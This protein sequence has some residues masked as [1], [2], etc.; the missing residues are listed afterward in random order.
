MLRGRFLVAFTIVHLKFSGNGVCV[1]E[2]KHGSRGS[3]N[4]CFC[5]L[6]FY[7]PENTD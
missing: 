5:S 3:R 2:I 7:L 6:S 1:C 4:S